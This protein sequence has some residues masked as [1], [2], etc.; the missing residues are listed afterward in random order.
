MNELKKVAVLDSMVEAHVLESMLKQR[1]I[2]HLI[3]SYHDSAYDGVFQGPRGWG[4]VEAPPSYE[5]EI[6]MLLQDLRSPQT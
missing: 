4:H 2:P 1:E 6:L 5:E 3:Q